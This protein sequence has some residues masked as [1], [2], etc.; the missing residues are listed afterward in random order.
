MKVEIEIHESHV[1][2]AML[3]KPEFAAEV[4]ERFGIEASMDY[5]ERVAERIVRSET[6]RNK[7]A[8]FSLMAGLIEET[9]DHRAWQDR[10][11][12]GGL[13]A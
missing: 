8:W 7:G 2:E 3:S 9:A 11:H 13:L 4:L 6:D 12:V 5:R 10:R 1:V